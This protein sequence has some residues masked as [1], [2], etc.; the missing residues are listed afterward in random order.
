MKTQQEIR[1]IVDGHRQLYEKSCS[2]SLVEMILKIEGVV[3]P[4]YYTLQTQ[5]KNDEIGIS[6]FDGFVIEGLK[7]STHKES[8]DGSFA[9]RI[10]SEWAAGR[11]FAAYT[12]ND[13]SLTDY[14]GWIVSAMNQ[15]T[16]Y[17]LSKYSEFG[18]GEGRLTAE[19]T[20]QIA[21]A[22]PPKIT[23]LLFYTR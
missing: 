4:D 17:L 7:F 5:Y 19:S 11:L 16:V 18:N 3:P 1:A 10:M 8:R 13:G 22:V 12:R 15:G 6:K 2:P 20:L 14:H 9:N 21:E 23:D